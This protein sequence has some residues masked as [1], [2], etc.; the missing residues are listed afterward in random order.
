MVAAV[1]AAVAA[2]VVAVVGAAAAEEEEE[3]EGCYAAGTEPTIGCG[4]SRL[5]S[6]INLATVSIGSS[7]APG[8]S[9]AVAI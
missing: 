1:A 9:A 7:K 4:S 5:F 2:V 3:E 8:D 6:M